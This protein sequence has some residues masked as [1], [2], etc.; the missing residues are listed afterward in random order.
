M[1]SR[2]RSNLLAVVPVAGVA[3]GGEGVL[4]KG[5]VRGHRVANPWASLDEI[6]KCW[7]INPSEGCFISL[8]NIILKDH[9]S[10]LV[11]AVVQFI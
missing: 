6:S 9:L 11:A 8:K 2:Y 4:C 10:F 1:F 7:S 5:T 3:G